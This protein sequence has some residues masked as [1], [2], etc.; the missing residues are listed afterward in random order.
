[1][2][3][4]TKR[5]K[6]LPWASGIGKL[7][8]HCKT[9]NDCIKEA[10]LDFFVK[11]CALTAK[12][13][14]RIN[15]DNSIDNDSFA[16]N[17][18]IYR[19][20]PGEYATY[21][22]DLN[23]PLGLVKSKY[24]VVQNS[25]AFDFF[26][27]AI[28][29]DMA[30]WDRAGSFGFGHKIFLSAKL[31]N[32]TKVGKDEIDNY[33]VFSNSHDGSSSISIM[34]T[35]IRIACTNMLNAGLTKSSSNIRIRHTESANDKLQIAAD[36]LKMAT[37]QAESAQELYNALANVPV[38]DKQVMKYLAD[39]NLTEGEIHMLNQYDSS[40]GYERLMRRDYMTLEGA[41]IS[42]RKANKIIDMW[43]Y[44]HHGIAQENI[45]GTAWGAYNAVTGYYSNVKND[46]G[47]KRMDS[48]LYGAGYNSMQDALV[49][50]YELRKA[51]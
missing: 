32:I 49:N 11:K 28:G 21:R 9:A 13:P 35:P 4:V 25:E 40:H 14:F 29:K 44:Y 39:L 16:Y 37:I 42:T 38:T 12:M 45:I 31:P 3:T 18:N 50:A 34:F 10:G 19:D 46:D 41:N 15:G 36:I 8:T 48:M 7:V 47:E 5:R 27:K 22:T 6:G 30:L 43:E 51:S 17:G 24:N 1:M 23:I 26:N 33:L 2:A 20:L